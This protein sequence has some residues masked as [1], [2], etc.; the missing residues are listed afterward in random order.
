MSKKIPTQYVW[1]DNK[2]VKAEDAKVP[3]MTHSLEYGSGIFEGI[4]AY[5]T[6]N[7]VAVFRLNEH[8]R[9]FMNSMKIHAMNCGYTERQIK[10]AI[11]DVIRKD[12]VG[13]CYIRP[14][15]FYNDDNIGL[16]TSGKKVSVF[17]AARPFGKYFAK[18]TGIRCKVSS[19]NRINSSIL[20]VEAK[21]SGNYINS[22][23]ASMEAKRMGFDE[24]ILL[25][26][27]GYVAEGPG[28]NIFLV[29]DNV[30]LTPDKGSD[31]LR[32][33]TRDSLIKLAESMGIE[34][35]ERQVHREELY[36][37][38]EL[39][40]SGTAAE[41]TSI[42]EVDG[43]KVGSGVVGPITKML[44]QAFDDVVHGRNKDFSGWLTQV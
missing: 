15:A 26:Q 21:A 4:R 1:L 29:R 3:I 25:S 6:D 17:V 2:M 24:A 43:I 38:D 28:E 39:F 7:G 9:R 8:V 5:E 41:L 27:N 10:E 31:I 37:A 13:A 11:L 36:T 32:G 12:G 33:I 16:S 23:I 19:W 22:I 20:P 14:F 30:L 44:A 34:V 40:F 18:Q 35:Q 42:T